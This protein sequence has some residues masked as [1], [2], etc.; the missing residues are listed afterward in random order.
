LSVTLLLHQVDGGGNVYCERSFR[1]RSEFNSK[2]RKIVR[3]LIATFGNITMEE[4][5]VR[6]REAYK[7]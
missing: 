5:R 4:L 7:A 1:K 6:R 2:I 3:H